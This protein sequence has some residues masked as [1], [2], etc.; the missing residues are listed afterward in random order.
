MAVPP[1]P[2]PFSADIKLLGN[3]LG[4][5]IRE[6]HGAP[7]LDTVERVRASAKARRAGDPAASDALAALIDDLDLAGKRILI[8]AFSSFFQLINIAEDQ[9]RIRVLREREAAGALRESIESAICTLHDAGVTPDQMRDLLARIRVR[10]VMTAHPTEAKR[11]ELLVKLRHIAQMMAR[12][13]RQSLLPREQ[14]AL[15]SALAEE[16]EELWQTRPTRATR[17]TVAD[18]VD[19][20]LYFITSVVMD[21]AVE[22]H[23]DLCAALARCYPG[24]DWADL[25]PLLSYASWIGGDRDGNPNVTPE[26]TWRTLRRLREAARRAYLDEIA[27]LREHL[28][29]ATSEVPASEPLRQAVE[30]ARGSQPRYPGELYREQLDLIWSRLEADTYRSGDDLLADLNLMV[31]SL[32]AHRGERVARGALGRLLL[33]VR[34]FGLHLVPLDIREDARRHAAALDEVFRRYELAENYLDLPEAEK[35]ALLA[36]EIANPR[37]LFPAALDF[38][39]ATN[40]VIET[41]RLIADAHA[42]Y[43]PAVIDSVIASMSTAPSDVLAMLLLASEVGVAGRVDLVPLFE[44]IQDLRDCPAVMDTLFSTPVYRAHLAARA[45]RQQIMLGYSDSNKDGGYLASNLGLYRAQHRLGELCRERGILLELFH[46]RG[47]SIGRGG[48]PANQGILAQPR[49]AMQ[50]PVKITEQGE[51][52]A[53]RYGNADIARRHLHQV[54]HAVLLKLGLPNGPASRPEW[55]D[56]METLA[57]AGRLAYRRF[58]YETPGFLDYWQQAT[59]IQELSLVPIGSRPAKRGQG[60]FAQIRAIPWVFSWMQSRAIIPSWYGVGS[61]LE[62]F[63]DASDDCPGMGMLQSMYDGWPFFNALVENV[64]LDLAKADMGIAALY[65]SLVEDEALRDRIFSEIVAEHARAVRWICA[66]TRQTELLEHAPVMRRSID[67]RNP[68]VDPLNFIQVALLRQ[69]R[70]LGPDDPAYDSLAQTFMFTV[71]GIAAGMKNT[72]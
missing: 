69:M 36:R 37:P 57:E 68:Y 7:A 3:L 18:E 43:G 8:K 54:I 62:A 6:Q 1:T 27:F 40:R 23:H 44:T 48:G 56:A 5:I 30:D 70:A 60:G 22:I 14:D 72:G 38:S 41:W 29:E 71:N 4:L 65:S 49:A 35:Q 47:G 17:A 33:K 66:I 26:V 64:Q 28:T 34:L 10:L 21:A 13:D 9:Q 31:E 24:V 20:G 55:L 59:P 58:V 63:C 15:E 52:I 45:N 32:R 19:F 50:G 46:G 39:D 11:Q 67:R 61:A 53:Y 16:I 42:R 2:D 51:V 12:R 25:P